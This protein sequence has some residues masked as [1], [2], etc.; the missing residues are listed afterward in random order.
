MRMTQN[1]RMAHLLVTGAV[2]ATFPAWAETEGSMDEMLV[3]ATRVATP[4]DQIGSSV[5]VIT[6][7]ELDA[8]QTPKVDEVLKSVPGLS[9][10]RQGGMGSTAQVR[11]RGAEA[12]HTLV[13]ID[14]QRANYQDTMYNF[15]FDWMVTD[16]IER[17]EV[18][19]GP[20]AGQWG[21]D[22]VGGV[23]NIVTRKGKGPMT[24]TVQTEVGSYDT[25]RENVAARGGGDSYDYSFGWSRYRTAGWSIASQ[26]RGMGTERDGAQNN[27]FNGKVGFSP[28]DNSEIEI[29]GSHTD[30]WAELDGTKSGSGTLD[31]NRSKAKHTD[32]GAIK[33]SLALLDGIWT[34]TVNASAIRNDQWNMGGTSS[35]CT[36]GSPLCAAYLGTTVNASWQNDLRFNKDHVT[37]IGYEDNRDYY[38][39]RQYQ[40]KSKIT[41]SSMKSTAPFFQHQAHL[42]DQ[43]DLG[44]GWRGTDHDVFGWNP[45]WFTTLAWHLPTDT[46]LKGSYGTTFKAPLLYQIYYPSGLSNPGLK[47]EQGRGWDVGIEQKLLGGAAKSGVTWFRNDIDNLINYVTIGNTGQYQNTEKATTYGVETFFTWTIFNDDDGSLEVSPS[48]TYTQAYDRATWAELPRRP[49]HKVANDLS[50]RF[51]EK[52]ARLTVSTIYG[53]DFQENRSTSPKIPNR[54]GQYVQLDISGSYDVTEQVQVYGRVENLAEDYHESAYGYAETGGRAFFTGVKVAF[55]PLTLAREAM[56]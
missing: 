27:T 40:Q 44:G 46:T 15:D 21:S 11:I 23:I 19:R 51:L 33:G 3:T 9:V 56:K 12:N 20:A 4:V 22:A 1:G 36:V 16:D 6:R 26:D 50:W 32:T 30:F 14:G 5:T 41:S 39:Q 42:F 24:V 25:N 54:M 35:G 29:R 17:I 38:W 8:R 37:T 13:L 31:T 52:K 55:E 53:S 49:R 7:D 45:T 47:A 48:Y 10:T 43:L 2:L 18:L 28:S 34:Q